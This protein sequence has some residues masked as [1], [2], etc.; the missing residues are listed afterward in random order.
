MRTRTIRHCS[1]VRDSMLLVYII[2]LNGFSVDKYIRIYPKKQEMLCQCHCNDNLHL[3]ARIISSVHTSIKFL[4][5]FFD[6]KVVLLQGATISILPISRNGRDLRRSPSSALLKQG[7]TE[8]AAQGHAQAAPEGLQGGD[9]TTSTTSFRI[10]SHL[11]LQL[12]S[13]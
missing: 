3:D 2:A 10:L 5:I 11:F 8:Q 13:V 4:R 12:S 7:R 6:C 1:A 9:F